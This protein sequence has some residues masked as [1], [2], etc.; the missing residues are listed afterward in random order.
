MIRRP[1]GGKA[2]RRPGKVAAVPFGHSFPMKTMQSAHKAMSD[3]IEDYT[4]VDSSS[5]RNF[6]WA[7][8]KEVILKAIKASH[9]TNLALYYQD[10]K[11]I[12]ATKD[13]QFFLNCLAEA[14][15]LP[16]I[17]CFKV[18]VSCGINYRLVNNY[19]LTVAH[20]AAMNGNVELLKY[21]A[22]LKVDLN[23][24]DNKG[25]TSPLEIYLQEG[26]HSFIVELVRIGMNPFAISCTTKEPL[27]KMLGDPELCNEVLEAARWYRKRGLLWVFH[28]KS[29]PVSKLNYLIEISSFL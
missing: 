23:S 21:L 5:I 12:N 15:K 10:D 19:G 25:G 9:H 26:D 4:A 13:D 16:S 22:T 27:F 6:S 7:Q 1:R 18:L 2:V 17:E 8:K 20:L 14:A 28:A 24:S 29:K 11:T 3:L